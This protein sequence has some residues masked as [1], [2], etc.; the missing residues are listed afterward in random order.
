[1]DPQRIYTGEDLAF[2]NATIMR[3]LTA[4]KY[5]T[6]PAEATTIQPDAATD[7]GTHNDAFTEWELRH[8]RRHEVAGRLSRNLRRLRLWRI[9]H[10][11]AN[12]DI[13]VGGPTYALP[14]LD[15]PTESDGSSSE[16]KGPY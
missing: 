5:S 4:Y 15:I 14:Y 12:N 3:S 11:P 8:S 13:I 6:D 2:F 1:M 10:L 16:S 9:A 7:L